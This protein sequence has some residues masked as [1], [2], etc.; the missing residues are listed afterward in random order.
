MKKEKKERKMKEP[1]VLTEE[2]I[3]K[4]K[5]RRV[6]GLSVGIPVC[7]L[8]LAAGIAV[9][10]L[11]APAWFDKE[12]DYGNIA[13]D[14][15]EDDPEALMKRYKSASRGSYDTTFK[16]YEIVNIGLEKIKAETNVY[17]QQIG[18]VHAMGVEQTIRATSIKNDGKYF[19]E[20]ISK[21]DMVPTARRFYQEG[22]EVKT[23]KGSNVEKT[24]ADWNDLSSTLTLQEHED[25]WGKDLS[26]PSIYVVSSKTAL[27]T[28]KTEK[29]SGG[30]K[31]SIDLDPVKGVVRYVKQMVNISDVKNPKFHSVHIEYNL[32]EDLKLMS[33]HI[34]ESYSVVM[35][36]KAESE[37]EINETFHYEAKEIPE[38]TTNVDYPEGA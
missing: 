30:Y 22:D 29:V 17:S 25:K 33:L 1:V 14:S 35:V 4:N 20:N 8:G 3:R 18:V 21:S 15:L 10:V 5:K 27:E 19:L 32:D 24:K 9:G 11:I 23:Y 28:S 7:A 34:K 31:V 26:R 38:L 16:P 6:I 13:S 12:I 36:V 2:E 37:G